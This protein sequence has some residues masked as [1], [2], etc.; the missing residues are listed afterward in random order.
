MQLQSQLEQFRSAGI[1]VVALTYDSPALQHKFVERFSIRYPLLSD[2]DATSMGNLGILNAD[3][4]PGDSNYGIPYPGVF[5]VNTERKIVGKV[6]IEGYS[7]R[8]DA[9]GVLRVRAGNIALTAAL[10]PPP[11][12]RA[13]TAA[14]ACRSPIP[15]MVGIRIP[16]TYQMAR[17]GGAS[18]GQ[19]RP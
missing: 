9:D 14:A 2:I 1:G 11:A 10:F 19:C 16:S 6:F 12:G 7:T 15:T 5:V 17:N 13:T 18:S 4:K 3:Y 8:V